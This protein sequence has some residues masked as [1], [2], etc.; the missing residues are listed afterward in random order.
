[1]KALILQ[2][3]PLPYYLISRRLMYPPQHSILGHP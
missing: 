2:S 3:S 1:M